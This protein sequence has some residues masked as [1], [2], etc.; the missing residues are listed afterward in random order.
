MSEAFNNQFR[1]DYAVPPGETLQEVLENRGMS[2]AELAE[3]T[4]RSEMT[5]SDVVMG[6]ARITPDFALQLERDLGIPAGFWTNLQRQCDETPGC[7]DD[8]SGRSGTDG[9]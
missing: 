9:S 2:L 6:E 8:R 7:P 3:K 4:G 1:P 5:I